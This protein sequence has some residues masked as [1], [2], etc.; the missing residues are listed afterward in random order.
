METPTQI[1]FQGA[2]ASP[3]LRSIIETH[4]KGLEDRFGRITACRVVVRA[5]GR[6][7]RTGGLFE[8]NVHLSLPN[9]REVKVSRT[10]QGD[11]RHA[12][13][14]YAIADAFKRARRQLQDQV[15][16]LQGKVKSHEAMP[17]GK[18][19][20][21]NS[22]RGFGYLETADGREI[23]FHRNSVLDNAFARL[24]SGTRVSFSEEEGDKGPQASTVKLL[25]KH[26]LR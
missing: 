23:Y 19:R 8:I 26:A 9:G 21:I 14:E 7:H 6:H 15:R 22:D 10:P 16:R 25:G 24:K 4:V 3:A 2:D 5:P 1:D 20:T 13:A 17:I 11:E 18:V 12:D